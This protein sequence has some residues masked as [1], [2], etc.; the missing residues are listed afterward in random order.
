MPNWEDWFDETMSLDD[1]NNLT[2]S[3][4]MEDKKKLVREMWRRCR[5]DYVH[6]VAENDCPTCWAGPGVP[7]RPNEVET[8]AK[9]VMNEDHDPLMATHITRLDQYPRP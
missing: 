4:S 8:G 6:A 7:C 2:A 5:D 3:L 9:D 1:K